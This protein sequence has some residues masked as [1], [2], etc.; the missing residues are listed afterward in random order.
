MSDEKDVH[1]W[2]DPASPWGWVTYQWLSLLEGAGVVNLEFH[3]MSLKTLNRDVS[4]PDFVSSLID[5]SHTYAL[6]LSIVRHGFGNDAT[7]RFYEAICGQIHDRNSQDD[8]ESLVFSWFESQDIGYSSLDLYSRQSEDALA[9]EHN[10]RSVD[11]ST[12]TGTPTLRVGDSCFVG[13]V[14]SRVPDISE[15]RSMFT[16]IIDLAEADSFEGISTFRSEWPV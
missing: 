11:G 8:P 2:C 9:S 1:L 16:A 12:E 4:V 6:A 5:R 15:A 13:P 14:I 10:A 3:P 7:K